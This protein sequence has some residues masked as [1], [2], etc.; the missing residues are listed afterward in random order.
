[1]TDEL[2]KVETDE[3]NHPIL[4]SHCHVVNIDHGVLLHIADVTKYPQTIVMEIARTTI[5]VIEIAEDVAIIDA[6]DQDED[7]TLFDD[8]PEDGDGDDEPINDS[9]RG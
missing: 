6:I 5:V 9:V 3:M 2:Q 8:N 1:M 4:P 7:K